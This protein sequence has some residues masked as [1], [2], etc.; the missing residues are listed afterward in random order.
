MKTKIVEFPAGEVERV[1]DSIPEQGDFI[2]YIGKNYLVIKVNIVNK[3]KLEL[4][5]VPERERK[6]YEN[7]NC[8]SVGWTEFSESFFDEENSENEIGSFNELKE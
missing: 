6:E 3:S 5:V 4:M 1:F 7:F 2:R 8:R